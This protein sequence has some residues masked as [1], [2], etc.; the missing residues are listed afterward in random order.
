MTVYIVSWILMTLAINETRISVSR[1]ARWA[2][3]ELAE[4]LSRPAASGWRAQS[5]ANQTGRRM[6]ALARILAI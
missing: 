1:C 3:H 4:P 2:R 6:V 5:V